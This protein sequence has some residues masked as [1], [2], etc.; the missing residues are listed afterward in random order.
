RAVLWFVNRSG[1]PEFY[2]LD[3]YFTSEEAADLEKLLRRRNWDCRI[4]K[5]CGPVGDG[6]A[7]S[8]NLL[9]RLIELDPAE[10]DQLCFRVAGCLES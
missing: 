2:A 1:E 10:A 6:Q 9:G 8:W 3:E 5:V 4:E 7:A